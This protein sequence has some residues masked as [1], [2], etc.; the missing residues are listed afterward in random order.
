MSKV[1]LVLASVEETPAG[2]NK[3]TFDLHNKN[4]ADQ[5][6]KLLNALPQ[7]ATRLQKVIDDTAFPHTATSGVHLEEVEFHLGIEGGLSIGLSAKAEAAI[8]LKFKVSPGTAA[9]AATS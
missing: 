8:T 2:T 3:F 6:D 1:D 7:V 4:A 5:A 9:K